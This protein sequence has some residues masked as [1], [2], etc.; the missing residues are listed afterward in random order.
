MKQYSIHFSAT[1]LEDLDEIAQ[2]FSVNAPEKL[3]DFLHLIKERIYSLT[4]L[5]ERCPY[6]PE[7]GLWG[8]EELRQL[9]FTEFSSQYRIIYTVTTDSVR[10][11]NIRHGSR[12]FSHEE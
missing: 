6:A 4:Q 1:A 11:L 10:I 2:W 7:N 8:E 3:E 12:R 9:L 5:P